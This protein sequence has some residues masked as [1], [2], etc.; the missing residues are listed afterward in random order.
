[1]SMKLFSLRNRGGMCTV[2]QFNMLDLNN[3]EGSVMV[4]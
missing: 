4:G 1:M 3:V 2:F